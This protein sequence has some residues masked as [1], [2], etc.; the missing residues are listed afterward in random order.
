[1][2]ADIVWWLVVRVG[3]ALS[4]RDVPSFFQSH[5][6]F[7]RYTYMAVEVT[8]GDMYVGWGVYVVVPNTV[9]KLPNLVSF[10][11][12]IAWDMGIT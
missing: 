4:G 11:L 7:L 5:V 10:G 3:V 12:D 1:M 2:L 8:R 9:E 6:G